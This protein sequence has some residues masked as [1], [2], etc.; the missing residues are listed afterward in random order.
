ML[1]I[2]CFA[3]EWAEEVVVFGEFFAGVERVCECGE[4]IFGK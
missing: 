2:K 1:F 4:D 3:G